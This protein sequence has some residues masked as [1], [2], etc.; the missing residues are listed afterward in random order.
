MKLRFMSVALVYLWT[1]HLPFEVISLKHSGETKGGG[2]RL[3]NANTGVLLLPRL[4]GYVAEW[5]SL[6]TPLQ[7][8]VE[9]Q[10]Y[11]CVFGNRWL[12][13]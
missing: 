12:G 1:V 7:N 4:L 3:C 11:S 13:I 5:L 8:K 10:L 2:F 6:A 9:D